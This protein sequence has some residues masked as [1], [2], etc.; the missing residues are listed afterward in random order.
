[1]ESQ[2]HPFVTF[3][4]YKVVHPFFQFVTIINCEPGLECD[5]PGKYSAYGLQT[6]Q[7]KSI[8]MKKILGKEKLVAL[9]QFVTITSS[10]KGGNALINSFN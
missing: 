4:V 3:V 5:R 9:L 8:C 6:Y 2:E 1:M 10:A 7:D